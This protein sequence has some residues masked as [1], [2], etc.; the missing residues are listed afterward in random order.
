MDASKMPAGMPPD[1]KAMMLKVMEGMKKVLIVMTF[2]ADHTFTVKA[3]GAPAQ[4]KG[5]SSTGTWSQ[6]GSVVTTVS[7]DPRAA[8]RNGQMTFSADGRTLTASS[9]GGPGKVVFT[10]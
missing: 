2:K 6:K 5:T 8:G 1:Q 4:A 3:E 9:V 10:R 7:K